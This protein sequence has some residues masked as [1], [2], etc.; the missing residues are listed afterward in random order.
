MPPGIRLPSR[1]A[2]PGSTTGE[3]AC[4][5]LFILCLLHAGAQTSV[6]SVACRLDRLRL[7][8][9]M[10]VGLN[11]PDETDVRSGYATLTR[12]AADLGVAQLSMGMSGDFE[13]AVAEGA[14][15]VRLGSA[16]FGPRAP[17]D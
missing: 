14:T 4:G 10:T 11:S 9:L 7:T 15:M 17:A 12:L 2:E 1:G 16:V 3:L 5:H 6:G 8:G 13:W